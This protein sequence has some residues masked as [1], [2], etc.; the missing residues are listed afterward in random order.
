MKHLPAALLLA[1]ILASPVTAQFASTSRPST[2]KP[3]RDPDVIY[4]PTPSRW[5]TRCSIWRR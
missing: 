4:V 2:P 3:L 5:S 1:L